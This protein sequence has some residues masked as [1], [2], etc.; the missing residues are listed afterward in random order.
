MSNWMLQDAINCFLTDFAETV[1]YTPFGGAPV[2][3]QAL[4]FREVPAAFPGL[5][6]AAGYKHEIYLANDP[7]GVAGPAKINKGKDT[8]AIS[9]VTG[10]GSTPH[11]FTVL[12]I[13]QNDA[14]MW[15]LGVG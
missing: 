2:Q 12:V 11:T 13:L 10:I 15:Q 5:T 9:N 3:Y 7:S 6:G 14:G 4:I 1:T 8:V